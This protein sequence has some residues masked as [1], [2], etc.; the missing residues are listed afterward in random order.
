MQSDCFCLRIA[1]RNTC[2]RG[3]GLAIFAG[4]L[5]AALEQRVGNSWIA[6]PGIVCGQHEALGPPPLER[7]R[8][9]R[10]GEEQ[11]AQRAGPSQIDT[12]VVDGSI[13]FL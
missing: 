4:K 8:I 11:P 12:S 6:G 2:P 10:I 5:K 1:S 9:E 13:E 7:Q 3:T